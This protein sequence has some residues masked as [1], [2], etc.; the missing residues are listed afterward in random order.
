V[1]TGPIFIVRLLR[2]RTRRVSVRDPGE[3]RFWPRR[4]QDWVVLVAASAGTA[5]WIIGEL[6]TV[7]LATLLPALG[8]G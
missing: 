2:L 1:S 8:A 5:K 3:E 4:A 6:S 7:D